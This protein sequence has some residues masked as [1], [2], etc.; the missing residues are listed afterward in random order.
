MNS[1]PAETADSARY[2]CGMSVNPIKAV[3]AAGARPS[4]RQDQRG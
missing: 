4:V 2:D 1:N 3:A